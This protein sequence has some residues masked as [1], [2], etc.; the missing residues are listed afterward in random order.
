MEKY[1]DPEME[2]IEFAVED[3]ITTSGGTPVPT[4]PISTTSGGGF[5]WEEEEE[6]W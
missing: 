6:P 2:I 5:G 1:I 4:I 3:I